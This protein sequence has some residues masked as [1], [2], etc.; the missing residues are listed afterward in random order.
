MLLFEFKHSGLFGSYF[1]SQSHHNQTSPRGA[2]ESVTDFS[3]IST[4]A[5]AQN[6][7]CQGLYGR[8]ICQKNSA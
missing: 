6:V 3:L 2:S 5:D 1:L 4:P 8:D 7:S